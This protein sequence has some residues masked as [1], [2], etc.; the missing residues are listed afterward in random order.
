MWRSFY[1][2]QLNRVFELFERE[3]VLV[4]QFER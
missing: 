3:R 1:Y 4:L 2:E